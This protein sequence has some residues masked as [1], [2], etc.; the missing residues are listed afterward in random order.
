MPNKLQELGFV[1]DSSVR[2]TKDHIDE[3]EMG[4]LKYGSLIEFP[5]TIMEAYLFTHRSSL[6]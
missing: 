3:N 5:I 2:R 4:Y 1:Y 6:E